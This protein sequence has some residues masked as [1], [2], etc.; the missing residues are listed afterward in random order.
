MS[1]QYKIVDESEVPIFKSGVGRWSE[2]Y[3]I[4]ETLPSGKW[5]EIPVPEGQVAGTVGTNIL[6]SIRSGRKPYT[7]KTRTRRDTNQ[8]WV[9]VKERL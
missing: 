1:D 5:V 9:T 6:M 3:P 7:I 2:L 4:L 8:L